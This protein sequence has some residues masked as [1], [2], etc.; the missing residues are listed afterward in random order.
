MAVITDH[1]HD[2]LLGERHEWASG[3]VSCSIL[4]TYMPRIEFVLYQWIGG[5][6]SSSVEELIDVDR[7]LFVGKTC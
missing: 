6:C 3:S 5:V 2:L 1:Q 4:L 7:K